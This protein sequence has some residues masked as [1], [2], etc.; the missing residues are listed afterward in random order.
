MVP[1][2]T[3]T[4]RLMVVDS[5]DEFSLD[6]DS[7]DDSLDASLDDCFDDSFEDSSDESQQVTLG[8][9]SQTMRLT[10]KNVPS[11]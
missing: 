10:S 7:L 9:L 11:G 1:L 8:R 5:S 2:D 3:A 4:Q 6:D